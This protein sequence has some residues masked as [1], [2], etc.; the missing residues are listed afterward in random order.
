[1]ANGIVELRSHFPGIGYMRAWSW[2]ESA[3]LEFLVYC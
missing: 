3:S 1:M 2:V